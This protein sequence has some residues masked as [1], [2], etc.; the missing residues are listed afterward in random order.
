MNSSALITYQHTKPAGEGELPTAVL[1]LVVLGPL[2]IHDGQ[3]IRTPRAHK[4]R[5]LLAILLMRA[6]TVV[7][8]DTLISE[9]WGDQPPRTALKALRVYVSQLRQILADFPASGARPVIVTRDPG[10]RLELEPDTFD[11]WRFERLCER[12]RAARDM[13]DLRSALRYYQDASSLWRGPALADVR[14][15][16]L[17]DGAALRLEEMRVASVERRLELEIQL[18]GHAEA[19]S[20]LR[21]LV[22][23]YPLREQIHYQ[24]I[25]A[26]SM[27]GRR[28]DALKAFRELR[29]TFVAELGVEPGHDLQRLHQSILAA[30]DLAMPFGD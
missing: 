10:Y 1:Q 14:S 28:G 8:T 25:L 11:L 6:N 2:E 9:I 7:S 17:L 12:G 13:G 15:S 18:G 23:D 5:V 29:G 16:P 27:A 21:V 30:D 4:P 24:L 3:C 19:I 20:E 22:A 26:L